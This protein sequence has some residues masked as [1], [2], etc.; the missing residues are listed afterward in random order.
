MEPSQPRCLHCG[1]YRVTP[2]TI[3]TADGAREPCLMYQ[4][5]D[6]G[7]LKNHHMLVFHAS[8]CLDCGFVMMFLK[9][10]ALSEARSLTQFIPA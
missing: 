3:T 4:N 2:R 7:F 8:A 9:P 10:E 5:P 1:S 6:R